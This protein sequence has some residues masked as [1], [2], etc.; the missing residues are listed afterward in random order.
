MEAAQESS[1]RHAIDG[2]AIYSATEAT[3]QENLMLIGI[4]A[5]PMK[6]P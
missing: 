2:I 5:R 6:L 3:T 4:K 1:Q